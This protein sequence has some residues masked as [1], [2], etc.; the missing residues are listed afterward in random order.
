MFSRSQSNGPNGFQSPSASSSASAAINNSLLRSS[1]KTVASL[2]NSAMKMFGGGAANGSQVDEYDH[3][4]GNV[5]ENIE[6]YLTVIF[7]LMSKFDLSAFGTFFAVEAEDRIRGGECRF[8][9]ITAHII[10]N[11]L[12]FQSPQTALFRSSP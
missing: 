3:K 6:C 11:V 7:Q 5:D 1:V 12:F 9:F 10:S 8:A 2:Q 4:V